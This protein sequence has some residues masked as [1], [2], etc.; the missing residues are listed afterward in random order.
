M[1]P[2]IRIARFGSLAFLNLFGFAAV[3]SPWRTIYVLEDNRYDPML[4]RHEVAHLGQMDRDGW[5]RFWVQ[6]VWWYF[7]PGYDKSP[8]EIE[9]RQAELDPDHPLIAWYVL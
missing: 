9:A 3:V 1:T 8:Y 2:R 5:L 4:L 7:V 6:C